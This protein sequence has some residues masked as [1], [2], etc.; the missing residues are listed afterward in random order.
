MEG[1]STKFDDKKGR[2][3]KNLY[4]TYQGKKKSIN[5]VSTATVRTQ[6]QGEGWNGDRLPGQ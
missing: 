3:K 5:A 4:A 1:N 2:E 6:P